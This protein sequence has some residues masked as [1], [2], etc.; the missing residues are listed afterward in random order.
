[1]EP[2]PLGAA[3]YS[4][5]EV[6]AHRIRHL[7]AVIRSI[8]ART[9]ALRSEE[10]QDYAA[11]LDGRIDA[12]AR[13]QTRL[14]LNP[15]AAVELEDILREEMLAQSAQE[16]AQYTLAGPHIVLPVR[17]AEV[18][19]LAFHELATNATKFGAFAELGGML[20]ISWQL[21]EGPMPHVSL[22]WREQGVAH[23]RN[24]GAGFGLELVTRQ[25]PY[26]IGGT[27]DLEFTG[28][29]LRCMMTFPV[30]PQAEPSE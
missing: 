14:V 2:E 17:V 28:V 18:L 30:A 19:T 22:V 29:G 8:V 15:D 21:S 11:H 7:V 5:A 24:Q 13:M 3:Y 26:E 4:A 25:A 16:G 9:A 20:D 23:A 27:V 6:L 10:V 1:V 12:F